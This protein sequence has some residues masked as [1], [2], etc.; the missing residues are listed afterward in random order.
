MEGAPL[1]RADSATEA[2]SVRVASDGADVI[3]RLRSLIVGLRT[4]MIG[5]LQGQPDKPHGM[6]HEKSQ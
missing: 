6:P 5:G 3:G 4:P 2:D 1:A